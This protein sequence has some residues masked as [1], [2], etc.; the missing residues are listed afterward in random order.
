[1]T[2]TKFSQIFADHAAT[3]KN[4][5]QRVEKL[6][7]GEGNHGLV[8]FLHVNTKQCAVR[9]LFHPLVFLQATSKSDGRQVFEDSISCSICPRP[10]RK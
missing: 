2:V 3:A 8:D 4:F 7:D 5:E 1:M 6:A 10:S 9:W